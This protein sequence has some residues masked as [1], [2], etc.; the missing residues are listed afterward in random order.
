MK[1]KEAL[2]FAKF[3]LPML[4]C[5]PEKRATALECLESEWLNMPPEENYKMSD[6]EYQTYLKNKI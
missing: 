6:E 4:H 3:L 5:Q 1:P 2:S